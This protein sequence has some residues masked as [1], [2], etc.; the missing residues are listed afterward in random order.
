MRKLVVDAVDVDIMAKSLL[1]A[2]EVFQK[3]ESAPK[4]VRLKVNKSQTKSMIITRRSATKVKSIKSANITCGMEENLS[5][6]E[7]NFQINTRH[8]GGSW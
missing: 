4:E 7:I 1:L 5:L 6:Y 3:M 2:E 8:K